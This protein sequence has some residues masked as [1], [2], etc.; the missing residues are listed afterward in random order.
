VPSKEYEKPHPEE[1][2]P[3][4]QSGSP[5]QEMGWQIINH[6]ITLAKQ[7]KDATA[8]STNVMLMDYDP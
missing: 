3:D 6:S 2:P 1:R 4:I 7:I 5:R 8:G